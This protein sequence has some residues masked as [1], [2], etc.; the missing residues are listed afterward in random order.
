MDW[1]AGFRM[2]SVLSVAWGLGWGLGL[3]ALFS[4]KFYDFADLIG[5]VGTTL[6]VVVMKKD[7][8]E[9]GGDS[10][11]TDHADHESCED[12]YDRVISVRAIL[13]LCCS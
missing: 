9:N 12:G 11:V 7:A 10:D 4:L 5:V 6:V 2:F 3:P 1:A 13:L 8:C